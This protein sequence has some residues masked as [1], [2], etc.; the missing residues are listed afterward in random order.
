M[1]NQKKKNMLDNIVDIGC[2]KLSAITSR[3]TNKDYIDLFYIL[4]IVSLKKLMG[5]MQYKFPDIDES[6]VLKSLVYFEDIKEDP[7]LFKKKLDFQE[8]KDYFKQ[9]IKR[10]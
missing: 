7:I 6:L 3:S 5:R 9:Q 8:V 4:H 10:Y 1:L 2:M